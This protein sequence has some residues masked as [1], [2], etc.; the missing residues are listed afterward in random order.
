MP[1]YLCCYTRRFGSFAFL[2][3]KD[4]YIDHSCCLL[5]CCAICILAGRV[6]IHLGYMRYG[7]LTGD[8]LVRLSQKMF[9]QGDN[10]LSFSAYSPMSR[11]VEFNSTA[12]DLTCRG[13]LGMCRF[14]NLGCAGTM[15]A[16]LPKGTE[17]DEQRNTDFL[18]N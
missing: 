18:F 12:A 3:I 13:V 8:F 6:N 7:V 14:T 9:T 11:G 4:I 2:L 17:K 15:I 1:S 10:I 5:N 16:I